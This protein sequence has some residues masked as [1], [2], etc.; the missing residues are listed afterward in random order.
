MRYI[1]S[2]LHESDIA[3]LTSAKLLS[4]DQRHDANALQSAVLTL[5]YGVADGL[6]AIKWPARSSREAP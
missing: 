4:E 2:P 5:V 3:A 6:V 1:R